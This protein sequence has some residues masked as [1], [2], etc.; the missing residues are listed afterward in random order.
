M[1]ISRINRVYFFGIGGIGMSAL[2]RY[3]R[4]MG[5]DVAG[6]DR[7]PSPLIESLMAEG[8]EVNFDD[9]LSAIPER[10]T[11]GSHED[12]LVV[13]TPALPVNH[14][15]LGFMKSLGFHV[16]KR[17]EA[18]RAVL[19]GKRTFAVA[20]T[21]GKTTT[22]AMAA[23]ILNA[24]S[25][26]ATAFL[27]G[28]ATNFGSNLLVAK[29]SSIAVVEADEYDR[30][31]LKLQPEIA[32]ITSAEADHL[33]IYGTPDGLRKGFEDFAGLLPRD[34]LLIVRE[35]LDLKSQSPQ[36]TY[37]VESPTADLTT[38]NLTVE[39]GAYRFVVVNQG[40]EIGEAEMVYPGRHN[41]E[42]ALAAIGMALYIGMEW[43]VIFERL[44]KFLGVKRRFEYHIRRENRVFIDDYAHH[45]TEIDACVGSAREMYPEKRI[46]GV[47]Q[48][49]LFSRTRDFADEFATSLEALN[50]LLL[51]EI[52][53]AREEPIE[54]VNSQMLLNKIRL[55]N[56]KLVSRDN[57]VDEVL[58]LSPEVL[59][60]M[61]AGDIDRLIQPLKTALD[62][63]DE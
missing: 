48:P 10:F 23:F 33:D 55:V 49:H 11:S 29:D 36:L 6:Y 1:T 38:K 17:S 14:E 21:H 35:G 2:A 18:L 24:E 59:L 22:S 45:P 30:S 37:A 41:V 25:Y 61:G 40:K 58:K 39:N 51:M 43:G 44:S 63:E 50:D 53:P 4:G 32:V 7:T 5:M 28:I 26:G 34:G 9:R 47:F 19:E 60:T 57:L 54:G 46:T 8:I 15:G 3:F 52:Y 13:Y 16:L 20:G 56:K 62:D 31:F 12:T 42:N 27:G